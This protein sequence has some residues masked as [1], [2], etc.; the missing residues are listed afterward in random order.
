MY[1]Q[2][3][4]DKTSCVG[5]YTNGRLWFEEDSFPEDLTTTWDYVPYMDNSS[6]ELASLYLQGKPIGNSIPEFLQ[7]DW[8]DVSLKLES[9]KRSF[10]IGKI[11]LEQNC[12]YDLVPQRFL[13][14]LCEVRNKIT[15][16]VLE[17][18]EKP[19]RYEFYKQVRI[20]LGEIEQ[21]QVNIDKR[22]LKS[23]LNDSKFHRVAE[24]IMSAA[25]FVRYNQFGT[26]TG[27]LSC[28]SGAFPIL[29]LP[30]VLK[31][32]LQPTNDFY[33]ELDFNGAEVRTLLGLLE[34]SQPTFDVH[35][36]HQQEVFEDKF[37][38]EEAKIAFFAWLYGSNSHK[39]S[40]SNM[41][42]QSFYDREKLLKTYW[43]DGIVKT[44]YGKE[45]PNTSKHH[46]LNYIIQ[47]TAAELT[48][49]QSLKVHHLIKTKGTG[50]FLAFIVHDSIVIDMKKED[51]RL[52]EGILFLMGS[53]NFGNF[54][55]NKKIGKNLGN[56]KEFSH[57]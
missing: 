12:F 44:F 57:G 11:N 40:A 6:L 13:I 1:F 52:L 29:T 35:E 38:R 36:F 47:S 37:S 22:F 31:S 46:A 39:D 5:I 53:T 33:L 15:Q 28:A 42:L 18:I 2:T 41:K 3:L 54:L 23:F 43:N 49:K 24:T 7:D 4:D 10:D 45:I 32:S 34:K 20:M 30:K 17:K 16:H 19:K 14:E 50:S 55:V 8:E 48:L 51:L 25:P 27:R 56:M 21:H 9:F 26:K